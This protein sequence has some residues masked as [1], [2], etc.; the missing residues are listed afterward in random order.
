MVRVAYGTLKVHTT[1]VLRNLDWRSYYLRSGGRG[2]V[3]LPTLSSLV[4]NI[5]FDP[6]ICFYKECCVARIACE[7]RTRLHVVVWLF[8]VVSEAEQN[9][10]GVSGSLHACFHLLLCSTASYTGPAATDV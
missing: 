2:H 9:S 8:R 1:F 7:C 6:I 10:L 4:E 5:R 3:V